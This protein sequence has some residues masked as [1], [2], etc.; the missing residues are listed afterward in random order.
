KIAFKEVKHSYDNTFENIRHP[1]YLNGYWQSQKYFKSADV[2][3]RSE[4][5]LANKLGETSQKF[6]DEILQCSAV[7]LHI[8]RGDYLTNPSAAAIH[9]V[10]SLDYY[11]SAIRFIS[12][13][14]QYPFFF[15][16]SDDPQWAKDN[17]KM[18]YPV[19]F[20]E[21]HGPD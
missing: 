12:A 8:R 21:A 13:H 7:S 2:K 9:G 17:L 14:V 10:C 15:V 1:M 11:Y 6:L 18:R 19:Q 4:F 16:F 5:C 3:L 20:V